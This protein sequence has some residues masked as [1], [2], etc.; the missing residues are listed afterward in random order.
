MLRLKKGETVPGEAVKVV[1]DH[2]G[3]M[4]V[5][6]IDDA[7]GLSHALEVAQHEKTAQVLDAY[8]KA[9]KQPYVVDVGG[10]G[11]TEFSSD[12]EDVS[13]L[14]AAVT[15]G[16][17]QRYKGK[18]PGET[19]ATFKTLSPP[20]LKGILAARYSAKESLV[21]KRDNLINQINNATSPAEVEAIEW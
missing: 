11:L 15:S 16:E 21:E 6:T 1:V 2:D 9:I 20:I 18:A 10:V 13:D 7:E 8:Y 5:Y 3:D 14:V 12:Q 19:E 4:L 17:A